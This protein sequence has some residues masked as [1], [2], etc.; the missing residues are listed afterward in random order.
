[1]RSVIQAV[2]ATEPARRIAAVVEGMSDVV[3]ALENE[4]PG[5]SVTPS[6]HES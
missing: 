3:D 4:T 1:M 2:E 6:D 5:H